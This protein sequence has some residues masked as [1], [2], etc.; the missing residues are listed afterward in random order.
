MGSDKEEGCSKD[1]SKKGTCEDCVSG[2]CTSSDRTEGGPVMEASSINEVSVNDQMLNA[3][4]DA[5]SKIDLLTNKM[6]NLESV[7]GKQSEIIV[8]QDERLSRVEGSSHESGN[9]STQKGAKGGKVKKTRVQEERLRQLKVLQE[10]LKFNNKAVSDSDLESRLSE[11]EEEVNAKVI[12]KKLSKKQRDLCSSKVS[13]RLRQTGSNFPEDEFESTASSGKDSCDFKGSCSHKNKIKSGAKIKKRPVLRTELWPHTIANEDDGD[14]VDSENI[15]LTKFCSCF[16]VIMLE[17]KGLQSQGRTALLHAIF[18]VLECLQ[19]SEARA[20]HNLTMVKIEQGRIGWDE[21]FSA[22][23]DAFIEKKVRG[24][25]RTKQAASGS[26]NATR[27]SNYGQGAGRG[28]RGQPNQINTTG[29]GKPLYGAICWQW[30]SSTCTYGADCKRWHCCKTCA[31][32]G[33]LGEQHKASSHNSSSSRN[34]P[35]I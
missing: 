21:D 26:S 24:S 29:K 3:L 17:C 9:E 1:T 25:L 4:I 7:I 16:T 15:G 10:Q 8:T 35:R 5:V 2:R 32:S 27:S 12:K 20:F 11:P 13:S 19:W 23:A 18:S 34:G 22:L 30:N 28:F 31:E 14:D 6:Q 33:K